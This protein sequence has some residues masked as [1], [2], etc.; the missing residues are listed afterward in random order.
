[1]IVSAEFE[2]A[3][4]EVDGVTAT[5]QHHTP[6][7]VVQDDAGHAG[8]RLKGTHMPTQKIFH[9]LI[10]EKLQVESA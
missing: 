5:L 9:G 2:Q 6:H 8:P 1:M 7:V 3:G 10:E 4:M